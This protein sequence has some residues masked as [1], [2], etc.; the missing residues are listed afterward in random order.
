MRRL[1]LLLVALFATPAAATPHLDVSVDVDP[2]ARTLHATARLDVTGPTARLRVPPAVTVESIARDGTALDV[3]P[4]SDGT[5]AL[6]VGPG[7]HTLVLRWRTSLGP[8]DGADGDAPVAGPTDAFLPPGAWHPLPDADFT[9]RCRVTVPAPL[10]AVAPGRLDSHATQDGRDTTV[11]ASETAGDDLALFV[12]PYVVTERRHGGITLRTWF[13]PEVARFADT[14]L[15]KVAGYLDLY[16]GWIGAYPYRQFDVVS[17]PLPVGLGFPGLTYLGVRV[18]GLPFIPDTSL[19]HEVL[20]AWWGN[21]VRVGGGGNWAEGLTTFMADYTF[22]ERQGA[23]EARALRLRW[24]REFAI[25]PPADDRPL[26]DFRGRRHTASQATGYH[27]AAFVFAMLRDVIGAD[28][29]A[30][31][32]RRFWTAHRFRTATWTDLATAFEEAARMPLRPFFTQWID[33]PGAPTLGVRDVRRTADG[34]AMTLTQTTP[35]WSLQVPVA[36]DA[37][38]RLVQLDAASAPVTGNAADAR[39][40]IVDPELRLFRRLPADAVPPVLREV[41]FDPSATVVI[42]GDA[43][44]RDAAIAVARAVLERDVT[45]VTQ[46]P[47][48][49]ALLIGTTRAIA[50]TL[51]DAGL[52]SVPS[53]VAGRGSARAFT[54]RRSNG[55]ALAVVE[56]NDADALAGAARVLPHL[57]AQS[58]VVLDGGRSVDRG[59]WPAGDGTS[60]VPVP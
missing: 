31:G 2:A 54:L 26:R 53:E 28:A 37:T 16:D 44:M 48:G 38:I 13:H 25:L 21:G 11:F 34:V 57:G 9:W 43:A 10:H 56:A 17:G 51:A 39:E 36:V 4:A 40:V 41:A 46:L 45:P 24:L 1:A 8:L 33:R 52:P 23:A 22:V 50:A 12:G 20:H 5:L 60:P 32:I 55:A 29:F 47:S 58:W 19:G 14:Y 42:V 27:K 7:P 18:V 59:V 30:D 49:P 6:R 15:G 3:A 35:A